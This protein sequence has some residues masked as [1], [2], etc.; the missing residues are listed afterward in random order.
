MERS[1]RSVIPARVDERRPQVP[2]RTTLVRQA[3]RLEW[4]TVAWMAIEA[5]VA[6]G[7]GVIA[8]SLML[9]AFGF[10]SV[11]EL[12]SAF[13]LIWCLRAELRHGEAFPQRTERIASRSGG[14]L[15]FI[16]AAYIWAPPGV[17][18]RSMAASSR[19]L[20]SS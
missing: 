20:A 5:L 6:I 3:F 11:I 17:S 19:S 15:L 18:G 12:I 1:S 4:L 9:T 14:A 16:L 7:S 8:G 10:D 13:V 2:K